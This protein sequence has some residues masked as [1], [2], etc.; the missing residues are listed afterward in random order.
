MSDTQE[1]TGYNKS[2]HKPAHH[3]VTGNSQCS[4]SKALP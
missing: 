2:Q 4:T 3:D 1:S